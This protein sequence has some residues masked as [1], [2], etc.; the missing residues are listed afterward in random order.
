MCTHRTH[1]AGTASWCT[2]KGY[3]LILCCVGNKSKSSAH[4]AILKIEVNLSLFHDAQISH[5]MLR[6]NKFG[7]TRGR[8]CSKAE[9]CYPTVDKF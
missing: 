9:Y 4:D 3:W 1:I 6:G 7:P 5:N 8:S 2:R